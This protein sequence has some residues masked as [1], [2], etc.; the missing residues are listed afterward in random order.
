MLGFAV[1]EEDVHGPARRA[2]HTLGDRPIV[3][4][5]DVGTAD[6]AVR[7]AHEGRREIREPVRVGVRVV[8]DVGNDVSGRSLE[9][10]VTCEGQ[11]LVAR[12][13]HGN[14][15]AAGDVGRVIRGAVVH[16]DHFIVGIVEAPQPLETL[17]KR[18]GPVERAH[19]DGHPGP[20]KSRDVRYLAERVLNGAEGGLR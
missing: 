19:N 20:G 4:G 18:P 3:G 1:A 15:I 13:D 10:D 8:V 5:N 7:G 9:T 6:R 11:A 17:L 12:L 2:R 16:H 14:R